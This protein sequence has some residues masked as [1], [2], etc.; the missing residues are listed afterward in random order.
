MF[1]I[2]YLTR[3][4]VVNAMNQKVNLMEEIRQQALDLFKLDVSDM[5][6]ISKG[7]RTSK[8]KLITNDGEFFFVKCYPLEHFPVSELKHVHYSLRIQS[9]LNHFGI[10]CPKPYKYNESYIHLTQS[11]FPFTIMEYSK[12][13]TMNEKEITGDQLYDLGKVI[14]SMHAFFSQLHSR[15]LQWYPSKRDLLSNL[16][17]QKFKSKLSSD[18]V[19]SELPRIRKIIDEI[20]MSVFY[21]CKQGWTHWDLWSGNV[22]FGSKKVTSILDFD[23]LK[24][25]FPAL[26]VVRPILS[27]TL[28]KN[29]ELNKELA[30]S[31][32]KGY[33]EYAF[34]NISELTK[35]FR[36]L[37][38]QETPWWLTYSER[39]Y[40]E[41]SWIVLNWYE[42]EYHL[43]FI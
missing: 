16:I 20:D 19:N 25:V 15:K 6:K 40:N 39:F 22:L 23:R 17:S 14:G 29:G 34:I 12:G 10:P 32:I 18:K 37:L 4:E 9:K 21:Q 5:Q 3:T 36:L 2:I 26:D 30:Q 13:K 43:D 7:W 35:A 27:F 24:Y 11:G 33:R 1:Y 28:S 42:L 8:W 31:L 41:L 38:L